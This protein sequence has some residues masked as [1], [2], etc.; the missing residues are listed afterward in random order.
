MSQQHTTSVEVKPQRSRTDLMQ[1]SQASVT[2]DYTPIGPER[3]GGLERVFVFL[4]LRHVCDELVVSVPPEY[5]GVVRCDGAGGEDGANNHHGLHNTAHASQTH[6]DTHIHSY[7]R[8]STD[9]YMQTNIHTY[10][11]TSIHAF[12]HAQQS[13]QPKD[14]RKQPLLHIRQPFL[15]S[16]QSCADIKCNYH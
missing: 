13:L 5:G 14:R 15:E 16:K 1:Q 7:K 3:H 6:T 2:A 8:T 4:K 9:T 12:I 10:I 11:H